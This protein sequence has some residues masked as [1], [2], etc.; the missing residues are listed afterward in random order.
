DLDF[1]DTIFVDSGVYNLTTNIPIGHDDSG[2]RIQGPTGGG[3]IGSAYQNFVLADSPYLYYRLGETS[4][5]TAFDASSNH[6][7]GTYVNGVAQGSAGG[8]L[9]NTDGAASFDGIND[10]I[11]LPTGLNN[12]PNGITMEAWVFPTTNASFQR[13]FDL[14]T[15]QA[16]NNIIVARNNA[17]NDL[18][19]QVY[20]GT[21]AGPSVTVG[22][23]LFPNRWQ[24]IAVSITAAG[25]VSVYWNGRLVTTG[26]VNPIPNA[27]RNNNYIARSNWAVD[28]F[29]KGSIDEAA[30][31]DKVL[32]SDRI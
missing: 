31:Y 8:I 11:Q 32:T 6:R 1:G 7:D 13:L 2:V 26:N 20:N 19:I 28:P 15:G 3:L 12:F 9:G 24:H 22:G 5:T 23:V 14:G 27:T 16:N 21:T 29:Y 25:A 18:F 30:I 17:S 4:G 10:H